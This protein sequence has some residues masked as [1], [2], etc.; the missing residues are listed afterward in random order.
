MTF[1]HR[2]L[3][4]DCFI[5]VFLSKELDQ[6]SIN[7]YV[8]PDIK[9]STFIAH[10]DVCSPLEPLSNHQDECIYFSHDSSPNDDNWNQ[11][12]HN[13]YQY[14]LPRPKSLLAYS[15]GFILFYLFAYRF[16]IYYFETVLEIMQDLS[17]YFEPQTS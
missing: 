1:E 14:E 16:A 2:Y 12:E 4:T 10:F 11:F 6:D 17:D 8:N 7:Q 5:W 15:I 3:T 9:L 13:T